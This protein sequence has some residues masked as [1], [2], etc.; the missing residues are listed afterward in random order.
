M[1]KKEY[2]LYAGIVLALNTILLIIYT[3]IR[4]GDDVWSIITM[5]TWLIMV[6]VYIIPLYKHQIFRKIMFWGVLIVSAYSLIT[7]GVILNEGDHNTSNFLID[8]VFR[9]VFSATVIFSLRVY[10]KFKKL[11]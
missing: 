5:A 9:I 10:E 8:L 11:K 2:K 3:L 6:L 7:E 4:I 1:K